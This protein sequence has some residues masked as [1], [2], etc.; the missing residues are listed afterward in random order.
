MK[1]KYLIVALIVLPLLVTSCGKKREL[2]KMV[3]LGEISGK[4]SDLLEFDEDS[5]LVV[6]S[7][8]SGNEWVVSCKIPLS[9]AKHW[10]DVPNSEKPKGAGTYFLPEMPLLYAQAMGANDE[11]LNLLTPHGISS[12]LSSNE[13]KT[14]KINFD[15][16]AYKYKPAKQLYDKIASIGLIQADL[17]EQTIYESSSSSSYSSDDIDIDV[18]VDVDDI[19]DD[20]EKALEVSKKSLEAAKKLDKNT[21]KAMEAYEDALDAYGSMFD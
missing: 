10:E 3:P 8:P 1:K 21:K 20:Y 6:L 19:L 9:N 7:N 18:D 5:V 4:N 2:S 12:L 13:Y 16:T 14:E 11:D 17:E 15:W